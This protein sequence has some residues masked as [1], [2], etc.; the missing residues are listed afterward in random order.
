MLTR[1]ISG[2]AA[3][4]LAA[5]A[6]PTSAHAD[7]VADFYKGKQVSMLVGSGAGGGFDAYA[8]LVARHLGDHIPGAPTVVVLNKPG[9]GSLTMVNALVNAGPFDG[10]TIGAP[11]SSA[12][13][14][15]L[16]HIGSKGGKAAKFKATE[17]HWLGSA[18]QDVFILFSWHGSKIQ[19]LDDL[20]KDEMLLGSSGPNTD[21]SLISNAL[22]RILGTKIKLISG[23][24]TSGAEMLAMEKGEIDG[25]AMAYAS[26]STMRPDWIKNGTIRVLAQMGT[27]PQPGLDN[28][29]FVPDLVKAPEDHAVL[30]LI[31]AKYLMG[32]PYFVPPGVPDDRVAALRTAFDATMADKAL[33][34]DAKKLHLEVRPVSGKDVQALV[35]K[36]YKTQPALVTKAREALGTK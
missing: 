36:L 35:A 25:N 19:S 11:Q 1:T 18:T 20:K 28:V 14:E 13:V 15:E 10:T 9:A 17:L 29:P 6:M 32:R 4:A 27:T 30:E 3:I 21:G 12:A 31:F 7:P 26:V 33:L 2:L 16:L 22:N 24:R 34:A 23:Y 5:L 8:R